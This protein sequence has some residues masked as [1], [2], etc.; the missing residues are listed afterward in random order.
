MWPKKVLNVGLKIMANH[1]APADKAAEPRC[2][3]ALRTPE[4]RVKIGS[5]CGIEFTF[6]NGFAGVLCT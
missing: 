6:D 1:A 4:R 2:S 5:F 3:G